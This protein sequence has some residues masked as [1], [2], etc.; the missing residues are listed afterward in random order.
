VKHR[1]KPLRAVRPWLAGTIIGA[2]LAARITAPA[3]A[4]TPVTAALVGGNAVAAVPMTASSG[5]VRGAGSRSAIAGSYI[6]MLKDDASVRAHG[7]AARAGALGATHHGKVADTWAALP[8]FSIHMSEADAKQLA[9]EPDVAY[10]EQDQLRAVPPRSRPVQGAPSMSPGVRVAPA[11]AQRGRGVVPVSP[12]VASS[13]AL[14]VTPAALQSGVSWGLDRIDQP[15]LPLDGK[16]TYDDAAGHESGKPAST[17][18]ILDSGLQVGNPDLVGRAFAGP[19]FSGDTVSGSDDCGGDGT[20]AASAVAGTTDGVAKKA[21]VVGVRIFPCDGSIG[22]PFSGIV[23]AFN[24]VISNAQKPAVILYLVDD[25]CVDSKTGA[26]I[27]CDPKD[28]QSEQDAE[29]AAYR[30]RI[31]VV[32]NGGDT[33]VDRCTLDD[34]VAAGAFYV[35]ATDINDSRASFSNYGGCINMWAPG[36]GVT[37]SGLGGSV[38]TSATTL[39]A[40]YVA[41]TVALFMSKPEFA[42]KGPAD[43]YDELINHRA[44]PDKLTNLGPGSPNRLLCTCPPVVDGTVVDVAPDTGGVS[45]APAQ[46]V[47]TTPDGRIARRVQ[48]QDGSWGSWATSATKGWQSAGAGVEQDGSTALVGL[49]PAGDVYPRAQSGSSWLN[50]H[51]LDRPAGAAV[52]Q[53]VLASNSGGRLSMFVMTATGKVLI[54][55]QAAVNSHTWSAWHDFTT[56]FGS[57]PVSI[58]ATTNASGLVVVFAVDQAGRVWQATQNTAGDTSSWSSWS[59]LGDFGVAAISAARNADGRV[60]LAAVDA[61]GNGWRRAQTTAGATTWTAWSPLPAKTLAV[62][63]AETDANGK[64]LVIG[65]DHLGNIWQANQSAQNATGYVGWTQ[66]DG[67]LRP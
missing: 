22:A 16:Y 35:G 48:N 61:G 62:I 25:G 58:A 44:T 36:V 19:N 67:K 37:V 14:S 30:N 17:V 60:E 41:G 39:A 26:H 5:G 7:V 32:H 33:G 34:G 46:L 20:E 1:S 21:N 3:A 65:V 43:F 4:D 12:P 24:W 57:K 53:T 50:W 64:V 54:R 11:V 15:A 47:G 10:V 42:G 38:T 29:N 13:G 27:L 52:L 9:A 23:N 51:R 63:G 45:G 18:Y 2:L 8:G 59:L 40:A 28:L 55:D 6:V 49:S 31:A 56:P 66:V